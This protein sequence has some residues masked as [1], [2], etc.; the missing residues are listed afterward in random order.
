MNW[1]FQ[2][3]KDYRL[4]KAERLSQQRKDRAK[5]ALLE[6]TPFEACSAFREYC[7]EMMDDFKHMSEAVKDPTVSKLYVEFL[8]ATEISEDNM[9]YFNTGFVRLHQKLVAAYAKLGLKGSGYQ[10]LYDPYTVDFLVEKYEI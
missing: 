8:K 2:T 10:G 4:R 5:D 6:L 1:V 3:I 9:K 7:Q